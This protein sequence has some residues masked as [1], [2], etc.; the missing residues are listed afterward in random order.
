MS[1]AIPYLLNLPAELRLVIVS[2]ALPTEL[3][4]HGPCPA[5]V[6]GL[7]LAC[8]TL[9]RDSSVAILKWS[10]LCLIRKPYSI[11]RPLDPKTRYR[12]KLDTL[13]LQIFSNVDLKDLKRP[14]FYIG[15]G[16][17]H[18]LFESWSRCITQSLIRG[19]RKIIIDLTP[20]PQ[21][22]LEKRPD[23][24]VPLLND[25]RVGPL[26]LSLQEQ[27]VIG[28]IRLLNVVYNRIYT[29]Y[30]GP[31][32]V[33]IEIGGLLGRRS[34]CCVEN[35]ITMACRSPHVLYKPSFVGGY[36]SSSIP[37][38]LSL[39]RISEKFCVRK[40][41]GCTRTN[42]NSHI[43]EDKT[44]LYSSRPQWSS[45]SSTLFYQ[46]AQQDEV[47]T[48][49]DLFELLAFATGRR[50]ELTAWEGLLKFNPALKHRRMLIHSLCR[51][52]GLG[53]K[54]IGEGAERHVRVTK[55]D[56]IDVTRRIA[57]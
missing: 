41:E 53:S 11:T 14:T 36:V 34:M 56:A 51:D 44:S 4:L 37:D 18:R 30:Y 17:S 32:Y 26:F 21:W 29:P 9:H 39:K 12:L 45:K 54:S 49:N 38:T 7:L 16:R 55:L 1:L 40:G 8:K 6:R 42:E 57:V 28:L 35:I 33:A 20:V 5:H 27:D 47:G 23:W 50:R 3:C 22:I 24:V 52:L 25:R 31:P 19:V 15:V 46:N 2:L 13:S 10:P 48:A 43:V